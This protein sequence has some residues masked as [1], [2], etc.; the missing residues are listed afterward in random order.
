MY[1]VLQDAVADGREHTSEI[2]TWIK[3][4]FPA[5]T[6]DNYPGEPYV[7]APLKKQKSAW[8]EAWSQ[9]T[10]FGA[11]VEIKPTFIIQATLSALCALAVL[12]SLLVVKK[13][14]QPPERPSRHVSGLDQP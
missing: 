6:C 8:V 13:L 10:G 9:V 14:V 1:L 2:R 5:G 11:S 4:A 12:A 7:Y 3:S